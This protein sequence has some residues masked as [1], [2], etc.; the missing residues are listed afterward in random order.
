MAELTKERL[1]AERQIV[2]AQVDKFLAAYNQAFGALQAIDHILA[3][4]EE[5]VS[6][7]APPSEEHH[8]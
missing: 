7:E 1:L 6:E 8:G 2:Q 3:I 5:V 4:L